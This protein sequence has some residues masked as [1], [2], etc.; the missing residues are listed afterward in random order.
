MHPYLH[1]PDRLRQFVAAAALALAAFPLQAQNPAAPAAAGGGRAGGGRGGG[2]AGAMSAAQSAMVTGI[3]SLVQARLAAFTEARNALLQASLRVPADPAAIRSQSEALAAAELA[4]ANARAGAFV[5]AQDSA[6]R[7]NAAQIQ[8]LVTTA[9]AGGP[10]VAA[11]P[12]AGGGGRGGGGGGPQLSD[13]AYANFDAIFPKSDPVKAQTPEQELKEFILQPGY[14]MELV[15]SERDD[16]KEP[17]A[18]AFDGNGRMFVVEIRGYMLTIDAQHQ[19]EPNGRISL[20]EDTNNDGVYDKHSVFVDNLVFPRFV[21]PFGPNAILTMETD[22]DEVWKYTDTNNDGKADKKE[23]FTTGLGRTGNVEHQQSFLTWTMDNWMYSTYNAVRVRWTPNGVLREATGA[24][25]GQWGVTQDN[26][27]KQWVQGGASGLPSYFQFPTVYGNINVGTQWDNEFTIP[28]GAPIRLADMQPGLSSVRMP[29]GT[30]NRVTGAAG[31]DIVRG[32]KMPADLQGEYIYGEPVARIVRRVHPTVS[33]GVT[34]L[35]NAYKWNEFVKSTDPLFRPV[36]MATAPDGTLYVVDMYR[37]IIQESQWSAPIGTYLRARVDQYQLDKLHSMGRVWRLSY[38]S[39]GRDKTLPRM[40]TQTAAQLVANLSHPNGWWRDTAQQLLIL[41]QDKSVVPALKKLVNTKENVLARFHALWTLEG[42]GSLDAALTRQLLADPEPRM[43]SQAIRASETLYK[44]GD[45]SFGADYAKLAKDADVNVSI[46]ALLTMN[47]L[48]V[49][50]TATVAK[51]VQDANKARGIQSVA[52]FILNPAGAGGGRGGAG[53]APNLGAN[54][55]S[56]DRGQAIFASLC[57]ECHGA[58]GLGAPKPDGNGTMAPPLAGS[59]RVLGHRDYVLNVLLKGL[60]GPI[61]G[62]TFSDIMVPMGAGQT[63]QWVADVAT[64]IR[65][66]FGNSAAAVFPD[67]VAKVKAASASR[68]QPWTF[69]ELDPRIPDQLTNFGD[70]TLTASSNPAGVRAAV[71]SFTT[72]SAQPQAGGSNWFQIEMPVAANVA[73]LQFN[74]SAGGGGR[75]G[76]GGRGGGAVAAAAPGDD[77][78]V[79]LPAVA[80]AA[81]APAAAP[82]VAGGRAFRIEVSSNGT[83]WTTAAQAD[84]RDGPNAIALATSGPVKFVKITQTAGPANLAIGAL[85]L[86]EAPAA[87]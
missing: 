37:G 11:A 43:R 84:G 36:D 64:Y 78:P 3:D 87:R 54:Q 42:L 74:V 67:Q 19:R 50:E 9:S 49:P 31:N 79:A 7:L 25:G 55:A 44:G 82:A 65:N 18:I 69:A 46:Q 45:K 47:V 27:G 66:S 10:L 39:L 63:D 30:L 51:A 77:L 40:N 13:P 71:T 83:S 14:K 4:L 41:K 12:A 20:H 52:T 2:G 6:D 76:A 56:Y 57:V 80:P 34:T 68:T 61:P 26:D 15:L 60:T 24:H 29:D 21:T 72:W 81:N 62:T 58:N 1:S 75:G 17:A 5:L 38:E 28:W 59:A 48:K 16:V 32:H 70:W 22:Q 53:A 33:E 23:L 8:A 85:R 86:F 73:E 35:A